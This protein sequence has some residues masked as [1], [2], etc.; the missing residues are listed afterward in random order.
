MALLIVSDVGCDL[1]QSYVD[2]H[3]DLHILPMT[4]CLNGTDRPFLPVKD[5]LEL[6]S[7]YDALTKGGTSST[8]QVT[9]ND[10]DSSF[11]ELLHQ[12]HEVIYIALSS[13]LSGSY[14][15]AKVA[16]KNILEEIPD[17]P[18]YVVDSLCASLGQGL[19]VDYAIKKR[20]E[21]IC[22]QEIVNLLENGRQSFIHW[23]TV[24][25][26]NFLCRGG[27]VSKASAFIGGMLKIKPVL[28]VN[29]EGKLIAKEK[30]KGRKHSL[31]RLSE[32][33]Q[34]CC[35]QKGQDVFISHGDDLSAA[36]FVADNIKKYD[37]EAKIYISQI[38]T[39]IGSHS[40]PGTVALF[41]LGEKR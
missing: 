35:T 6:K 32:K 9:F 12:G 4:Y 37:P 33:Y 5:E 39:V 36:Q 18:L 29:E 22:A 34:E 13:G 8:A 23:F 17:A 14:N 21:G 40:G 3:K 25:D 24:D 27:R 26:L 30:V 20:D 10:Y 7:F 2:Q 41:F 1:P 11:R 16:Q 38:G 19:L 31:K 28:H 15:S